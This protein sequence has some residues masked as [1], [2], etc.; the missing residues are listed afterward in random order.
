MMA[1]MRVTAEP[2]EAEPSYGILDIAEDMGGRLLRAKG[3]FKKPEMRTAP[4]TLA[5]IWRYIPEPRFSHRW[6]TPP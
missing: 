3:M 1:T 6:A 2:A 5:I 4:S